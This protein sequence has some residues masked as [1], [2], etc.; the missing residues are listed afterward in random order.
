MEKLSFYIIY[1]LLKTPKS[2]NRR[3]LKT[4]ELNKWR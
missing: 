4:S 1:R 2:V 3:V